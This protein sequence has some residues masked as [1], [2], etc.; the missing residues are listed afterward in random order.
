MPYGIVAGDFNGDGKL[1]MAVANYDQTS[2]TGTIQIY[3]GQGN[4][5][6]SAGKTYT[7]SNIPGISPISI[8]EETSTVTANSTWPWR[9]TMALLS[10]F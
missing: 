3:L 9:T 6:F 8:A 1:D 4:G 7:S 10:R 5:T 2:D